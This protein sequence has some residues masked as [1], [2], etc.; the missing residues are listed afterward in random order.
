MSFY[1]FVRYTKNH[2]ARK[3]CL[4]N[5]IVCTLGILTVLPTTDIQWKHQVLPEAA[6]QAY[7]VAFF[8]NVSSDTVRS[9]CIQPTLQ[10]VIVNAHLHPTKR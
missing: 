1:P 4:L 6:N 8:A 2:C 9:K 7:K 3:R 10:P 5:D